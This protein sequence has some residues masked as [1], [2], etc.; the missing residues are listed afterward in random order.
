[1]LASAVRAAIARVDPE[2]PVQDVQTF[3]AIRHDATSPARFRTILLGAFALLAMTLSVVGVFGVLAYVVQ[4]RVREFG[5][6]IALGATA[7]DV[8]AIVLGGTARIV[9]IGIVVGLAAAAAAGRSM[10]TLLF[11]VHPTDPVTFAG[12]AVLLG[13][14]ATLAT[15]LPALRAAR[16]DPVVALRDE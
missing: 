7:G 6:R 9:G 4:Q 8:L 3:A 2:R 15:M 14:T 12:V 11:G 16:V 10:S 5:I 1:M 13:L